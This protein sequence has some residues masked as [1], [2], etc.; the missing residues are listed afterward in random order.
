MP[1]DLP[2]LMGPGDLGALLG[3]RSNTVTT[4]ATRHAD[5]PP[6]VARV[7]AGPVYNTA[8]VLEW[9]RRTGH[10]TPP[11]EGRPW[12]QGSEPSPFMS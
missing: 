7:R 8:A 10:G 6:P 4:W 3:V 11:P 1:G 9:C 2:E 12:G 5:F